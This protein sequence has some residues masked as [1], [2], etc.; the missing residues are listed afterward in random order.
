M[1]SAAIASPFSAHAFWIRRFQ[2]SASVLGKTIHYKE[3]P[4]TVVGV[5][6]AGFTGVE[7]E[8]SIDLWVPITADA[9]RAWLT[10]AHNHWLRI[11]M[12][13]NP[14]ANSAE[15]QG[16]LDGVFRTHVARDVLPSVPP[17]FQRVLEAQHI[18]LR[19]AGSGLSTFGRRYEKPLQ[20]L[21]AVVALVLLIS[22]A[23]VAN[24][25][26]ARNAARQHEITLRLALGAS[27]GRILSQLFVESLL[28]ALSGAAAGVALA[29]WANGALLSLLPESAGATRL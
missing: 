24:L 15:V 1:S 5:A 16:S 25:V 22:C 6:Q 23:N 8:T 27:R 3:T 11:L 10:S 4:Y 2:S 9:A 13:L 26:L 20:L 19:P 14:G 18:R 29:V 17:H 28:L 21:M 12:R 7:A